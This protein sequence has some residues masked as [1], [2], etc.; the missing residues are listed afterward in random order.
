MNQYDDVSQAAALLAVKKIKTQL[1]AGISTN[2]ETKAHRENL[3]FL[4]DQALDKK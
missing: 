4:I 3:V 1:A 2:E